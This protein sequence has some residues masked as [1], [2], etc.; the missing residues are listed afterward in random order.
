M[1]IL[2]FPEISPVALSILG[3]DIYWYSFAYLIG[4]LAGYYL[5]KL[6]NSYDNYLSEK[7]IEDLLF[8]SVIG[9]IIGGRLGFC[10]VYNLSHTIYNPLNILMIREGGMSFHG[11]LIGV[12]IAITTVAY[13]YMIPV[14]RI[15]DLLCC[16]APIGIFLGRIAN[17]INA[18]MYGK[19]TTQ[20][21]GIVFPNAGYL[22]RHPTQIYE[23]LSEGLLLFIIMLLSFRRMRNYKGFL[24]ATFLMGYAIARM[25]IENY[26][27]I[28]SVQVY[29]L[30]MGQILTM[31]MM[32]IALYLFY[33]SS[34]KK[35]K[36][37]K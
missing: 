34:C 20:I 33:T 24:T 12:S 25:V 18:E 15:S 36:I 30:S 5:F 8:Y 28:D 14:L 31:P 16:V 29:C 1:Q 7:A 32:L 26:K 6:L 17:F 9:I 27:E 3:F 2:A 19:V 23:A 4:I 21:W 22:P 11:G 37:F 13:K 35:V 10:F